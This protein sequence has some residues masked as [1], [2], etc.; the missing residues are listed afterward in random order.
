MAEAFLHDA[1]V[2]AASSARVV[3]VWCM[4][5]IVSRGSPAFL[6]RRTSA[7]LTASGAALID[8]HDP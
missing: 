1:W 4:P 5:F 6:T 2:D 3:H 8:D 7:A